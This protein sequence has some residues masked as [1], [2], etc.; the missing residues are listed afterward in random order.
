M[1]PLIG[2]VFVAS[3]LGSAHCAGMCGAFVAFAVSEPGDTKRAH[4][5]AAYNGGRLVTYMI[6]GALAGLLGAAVDL[7]GA[8]AGV[9]RAAAILAGAMMICV[10]I[11]TL[12]RMAG[13]RVPHMPVP[14]AMQNVVRAGHRASLR[15]KPVHRALL[16]GLLT[17]LL[18]C[19]WLYAFAITA[20][21]TGS[22][23]WGAVTMAAFWFG[24]L[25]IMLSLG[26]SFQVFTGPLRKR[27]PLV[28][29][30]L[31]VAV[32]LGAV[33]GRSPIAAAESATGEP[34]TES[35]ITRVRSLDSS[36]SSCCE[37]H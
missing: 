9:Q 16:T 34:S 8:A 14:K 24:T 7:G 21:G 26:L 22:P 1:I 19:G 15:W 13:V 3:L 30:L 27:L 28:T 2:A 35:L 23:L 32:G 36:E 11:V 4:L 6:L 20:S 12:V 25:P 10:G 33:F 29:S 31:L 5:H 17:T 37:G 18:P